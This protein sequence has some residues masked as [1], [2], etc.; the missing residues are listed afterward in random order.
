MFM[1]HQWVPLTWLVKI[2][3]STQHSMLS[4]VK[5][6][7]SHGGHLGEF[8]R[9]K[10]ATLPA[11]VCYRWA[12]LNNCALGHIAGFCYVLEAHYWAVALIQY[13][14][15]CTY[16]SLWLIGH[17]QI[18]VKHGINGWELDTNTNVLTS[19]P[20]QLHFSD[21]VAS[22]LAHYKDYSY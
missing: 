21:S 1:S 14:L 10:L 20:V 16:K 22:F 9:H 2:F 6:I 19:S 5:N 11:L 15:T 17:I 4:T 18:C 12:Y 3:H 8:V 7:G 13:W